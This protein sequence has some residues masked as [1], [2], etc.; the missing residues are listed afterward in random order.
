MPS[1]SPASPFTFARLLRDGFKQVP[2][3]RI[4]RSKLHPLT[5]IL[6]IALCTVLCSGD[7]YEHMTDWAKLQG[8]DWLRASL[9]LQLP[10]G[11]PHHDT[12]RRVLSRVTPQAVEECLLV[13][14]KRCQVHIK[15]INVDG[16]EL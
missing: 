6:M 3:P 4:D 1:P 16:K 15:Q 13:L 5:D 10:N 11:I 7:A 8:V 9:G 14:A 2:D 12:F